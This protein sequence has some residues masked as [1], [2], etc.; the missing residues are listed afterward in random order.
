MTVVDR[1]IPLVPAPF[2]T[3]VAGEDDSGTPW[4][5]RFYLDRRVRPVLGDQL[6]RWQAAKQRP[7]GPV[8]LPGTPRV[9]QL[10]CTLGSPAAAPKPDGRSP[11]RP[12]GRCS[13]PAARYPAI[14]KPAY[15]PRKKPSKTA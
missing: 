10:L 7:T 9:P 13:G 8:T 1:W 4:H 6:P 2:G 15:R 11:G 14:K 3:R 5:R 12:K